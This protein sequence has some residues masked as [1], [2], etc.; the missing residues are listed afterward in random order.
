MYYVDYMKRIKRKSFQ[1]LE[2]SLL[3]LK[4]FLLRSLYDWM[5]ALSE[6]SFSSLEEFI[7]LFNIS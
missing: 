3:E 4:L 6:H 1:G 5:A 2:R 7:D